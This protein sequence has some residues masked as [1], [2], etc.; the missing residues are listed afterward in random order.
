M[1]WLISLVTSNFGVHR[2]LI[3][4]LRHILY[5]FPMEEW[6]SWSLWYLNLVGLLAF[7]YFLNNWDLLRFSE[8]KLAFGIHSHSMMCFLEYAFW[9][10]LSHIFVLQ[11]AKSIKTSQASR[12]ASIV[13][14]LDMKRIQ[15]AHLSIDAY[16]VKESIL[17]TKKMK[18]KEPVKFTEL[19][20]CVCVCVGI[21]FPIRSL[22]RY[23]LSYW[24]YCIFSTAN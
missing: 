17:Q 14:T 22:C 5:F 13:I 24:Y 7:K 2:F 9:I 4:L 1:Y 6:H 23:F 16:I 20:I 10:N 15:G 11:V 19:F 8:L 12:L 18:L 21:H 3:C